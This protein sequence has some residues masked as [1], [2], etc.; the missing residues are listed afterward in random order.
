M[1]AALVLCPSWDWS[2]PVYSQA[3]LAAILRRRGREASIYDLNRVLVTLNEV[4]AA[5]K[6]EMLA[7]QA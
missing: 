4:P 7:A 1:K 2:Y 6:P 5:E 3:L